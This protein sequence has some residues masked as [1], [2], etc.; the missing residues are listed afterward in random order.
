MSDAVE[1]VGACFRGLLR[2][3]PSEAEIAAYGSELT[4]GISLE[5]FLEQLSGCSEF[6]SRLPPAEFVPTGHFYSAIPRAEAKADFVTNWDTI[7]A[8]KHLPGIAVDDAVLAGHFDRIID[9]VHTAPFPAQKTPPWRYHFDNPAYSY[10][11][12]LSLYAMMLHLRPQ[13]ILEVGSGYSSALMMDT[14]TQEFASGIEI[15][16]IEPHPELL[17][18]LFN[19]EDCS[20]YTVLSRAVQEIDPSLFTSLQAKDILFI[21]STHVAKLGSDVNY[22]MFEILP[23]LNPGVCVHIHD[24]F[25]PFEYPATW[26]EEGRVWNEAYI[27]R[28]VLLHS[29]R[30]KILYFSDYVYSRQRDCI[31]RDAPLLA[32]NPGAHIWLQVCG[33]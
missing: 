21:D 20:R 15:T 16:F 13:R 19:P 33:T 17:F 12:G 10:G 2:R 7:R 30:L 28:A 4:N 26:V 23:R 18:S 31:A 3:E 32:R 8:R 1:L 27:V 5:T 14:N 9:V 29:T 6:L 24:I 22:L 25:W 11:D